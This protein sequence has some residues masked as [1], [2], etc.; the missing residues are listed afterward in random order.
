MTVFAFSGLGF[1]P[2]GMLS[3]LLMIWFWIIDGS[4]GDWA[5]ACIVMVPVSLV[6]GLINLMVAVVVNHVDVPGGDYGVWTSRHR[7]AG[8]PVQ[9]YSPHFLAAAGLFLAGWTV[10][11]VHGLVAVAGYAALTAAYYGIPEL[12][13]RPAKANTAE[14]RKE[15]AGARGW[16][17]E[18]RLP[19]LAG[20]WVSGPL[21]RLA[22]SGAEL[23]NSTAPV[24]LRG[25][26]AVMAGTHRGVPFT[27][28]DAFEP[29]SFAPFRAW[30][31]VHVTVCA[32]HLDTALPSLRM[33]LRRR[34]SGRGSRRSPLTVEVDTLRPDFAQ[35][36]VTQEVS[37][38]ML[39]ARVTEWSI[40]GRDA[41]LVLRE[42]PDAAGDGSTGD[43]PADYDLDAV[44]AVERLA[45]V[46]SRL[47]SGI[48]QWADGILPGLPL[49]HRE[50]H[51]GSA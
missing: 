25:C 18:D 36:V 34:G 37:E 33:V 20:R 15:F 31:K 29:V 22:T 30:Q 50:A 11:W 5:T 4:G 6:F 8:T 38:A 35:A 13:R 49:A 3:A 23:L 2:V 45:T 28:A 43:A 39:A 19:D 16:A 24:K 46:V 10:Q 17:F 51:Q 48:D 9:A 42:S 21:P 1:L 7:S 41:L 47:P 14:Q 12:L 26:F 32:V 40:Q 27:V 44:R